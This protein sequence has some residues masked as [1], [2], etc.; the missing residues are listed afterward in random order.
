MFVISDY[1]YAVL[2]LD[3]FEGKDR[4]SLFSVLC[5]LEFS[6]P[7]KAPVGQFARAVCCGG[8][9]LTAP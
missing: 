7:I 9:T 2:F 1:F 3:Y 6:D 5:V 8:L 4:C